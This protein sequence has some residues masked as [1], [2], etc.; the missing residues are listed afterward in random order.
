MSKVYQIFADSLTNSIWSNNPVVILQY[1]G[2]NII[3]STKFT[4]LTFN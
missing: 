3:L 4:T 2:S 1:L